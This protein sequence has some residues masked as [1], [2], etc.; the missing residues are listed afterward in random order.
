MTSTFKSSDGDGYEMGRWSQRLASL[1]I[2][3]SETSSAVG[4]RDVGCGT[5]HLS[6]C[7]AQDPQIQS[8][9]GSTFGDVC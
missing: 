7:L 9:Y 1:F 8:V 4:V 2:K 5:G 6:F 3:F